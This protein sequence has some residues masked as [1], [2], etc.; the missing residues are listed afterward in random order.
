M[1]EPIFFSVNQMYPP[2]AIVKIIP[3]E[4]TLIHLR[5]FSFR[6]HPFKGLTSANG[7]F[8]TCIDHKSNL[9]PNG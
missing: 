8:F 1:L 9:V 7:Y 3:L 6:R 5:G 2:C 4:L